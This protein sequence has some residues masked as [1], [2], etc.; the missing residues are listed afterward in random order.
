MALHDIR[1]IENWIDRLLGSPVPEAGVT[2]IELEMLPKRLFP[3]RMPMVFALPD[4]TRFSLCDFPLHLP[5]ELLGV[6]K[7]LQAST[8]S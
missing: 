4:N 8:F 6:N 3:N 5:L 1:E 7:C 2:K